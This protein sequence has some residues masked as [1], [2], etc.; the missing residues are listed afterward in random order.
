MQLSRAVPNPLPLPTST[1]HAYESRDQAKT[2]AADVLAAASRVL[3]Q[4]SGGDALDLS[5]RSKANVLLMLAE[6]HKVKAEVV[7]R[8]NAIEAQARADA[9]AAAQAHAQA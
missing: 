1:P 3:N 9:Q 5:P 6:L 8:N 2:R 7:E 4:A